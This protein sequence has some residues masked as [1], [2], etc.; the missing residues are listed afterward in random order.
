MNHPWQQPIRPLEVLIPD[1]QNP[2]RTFWVP[3]IF[4]RPLHPRGWEVM[5]YVGNVWNSDQASIT[6]VRS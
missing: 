5:T 3:V 1:V 2:E 4:I 6:E